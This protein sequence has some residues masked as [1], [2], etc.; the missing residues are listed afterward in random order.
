M[1]PSPSRLTYGIKPA[2]GIFQR[3]M[4]QILVGIPRVRVR[5]DD[6]LIATSGGIKE[7]IKVLFEVFRRLIK[8]NVKLKGSKCQFFCSEVTYMGYIL[9]TTG[10][11]PVEDKLRAIKEAPIPTNRFLQIVFFPWECGYSSFN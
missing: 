1:S 3:I 8:Y 7:H 4:D 6:I 10:I 9:N 11:H 2:P 5:L